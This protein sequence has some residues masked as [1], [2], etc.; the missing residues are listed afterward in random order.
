L[1][2]VPPDALATWQSWDIVDPGYVGVMLVWWPVDSLAR[3][4]ILAWLLKEALP[5]I[6]LRRPV[7][8]VLSAI[9]AEA[10][11]SVRVGIVSLLGIVPALTLLAWW[12]VESLALRLALLALG[13]LGLLP[14]IAY[15]MRR[16]L[17]FVGILAENL[18]G[19]VALDW[20]RTRLQG[21]LKHFLRLALPWWALSLVLELLNFGLG[22]GDSLSLQS[23]SW[24][25]SV[26][27][28]LASLLPMVLF[29]RDDQKR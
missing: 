23:L 12:G 16:S 3:L 4:A 10:L 18:N 11:L 24:V 13:L 26:P 5:G 7:S 29:A 8:A 2:T 25:L 1:A 6:Q 15:Y 9:N 19:P 14:T 21:H 28:L 20:S 17:A 22:Q 27:S